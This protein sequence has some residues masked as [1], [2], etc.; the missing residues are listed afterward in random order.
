MLVCRLV[1]WMPDWI[2]IWGSQRPFLMCLRQ[3]LSSSWDVAGHFV[4]LQGNCHWG[5][6]NSKPYP[7][8]I[9]FICWSFYWWVH[10]F[11]LR[12]WIYGL[13]CSLQHLH[14]IPHR[15][16]SRERGCL[17]SVQVAGT[18]SEWQP[19]T[20][21]GP[22]GS[23][24]PA[25]TSTTAEVRQT[26]SICVCFRVWSLNAQ[27]ILNVTPKYLRVLQKW[28]FRHW[29]KCYK[30]ADEPSIESRN[31]H[32]HHFREKQPITGWMIFKL[33][34]CSPLLSQFGIKWAMINMQYLERSELWVL[35]N[36][37]SLSFRHKSDLIRF[38]ENIV[39]LVKMSMQVQQHNVR[40][41]K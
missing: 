11:F 30:M 12:L 23:P 34:R 28:L 5:W 32:L 15:P 41:L 18:S 16:R 14:L 33:W 17:I 37:H 19:S 26:P 6:S 35:L 38:P 39:A 8:A 22:E 36:G 7:C 4:L 13:S 27:M 1:P 9:H 3:F 25:D 2:G 29:A 40:N 24:R 20:P 21:M 10:Y 31:D